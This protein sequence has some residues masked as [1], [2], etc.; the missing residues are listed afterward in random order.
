MKGLSTLREKLDSES[1]FNKGSMRTSRSRLTA[2]LCLHSRYIITLKQKR[3]TSLV[4]M[5]FKFNQHVQ[6]NTIGSN[7]LEQLG[8]FEI[9]LNQVAP[10]TRPFG[11]PILFL[12]HQFV[13]IWPRAICTHSEKI[14]P[15]SQKQ[16][17]FS[18]FHCFV[19]SCHI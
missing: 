4:V 11:V 17:D 7:Q 5:R 19:M 18:F 8:P 3:R 14:P 12:D 1:V 9:S 15:L 10:T 2:Y 13:Y 6:S 16:D